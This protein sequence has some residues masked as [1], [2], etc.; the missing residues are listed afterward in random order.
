MN[1]KLTNLDKLNIKFKRY[2]LQWKVKDI[3]E[4]FNVNVRTI[5]RVLKD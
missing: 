3:A 4:K 5:Y 2:I 1:V